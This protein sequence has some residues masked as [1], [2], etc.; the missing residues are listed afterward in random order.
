MGNANNVESKCNICMRKHSQTSHIFRLPCECSSVCIEHIKY[1]I[2]KRET[3][4]ICATCHRKFPLLESKKSSHVKSDSKNLTKEKEILEHNLKRLLIDYKSFNLNKFSIMQADHFA[5]IR[6]SIDIEREMRLKEI[7]SKRENQHQLL[8]KLI[9]KQSAELIKA[10]ELMEESFRRNFNE[11]VKLNHI[12]VLYLDLE[13][14]SEEL[15]DFFKQPS[16]S[17]T[18]FKSEFD[19]NLNVIKEKLSNLKVA[20]FF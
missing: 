1:L 17:L 14:M 4:I 18:T 16:K 3:S 19:A 10:V 15:K 13:K 2:N 20:V 6:N 7:Y 5:S 8:A 9:N 11:H 12:E